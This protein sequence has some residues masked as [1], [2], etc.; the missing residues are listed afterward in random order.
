MPMASAAASRRREIVGGQEEHAAAG[1]GPRRLSAERT[2]WRIAS[3]SPVHARGAHRRDRASAGGPS[4][5]EQ[6]ADRGEVARA[7]R[8]RH[9][10]GDLAQAVQRA[11]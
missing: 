8:V 10:L 5:V 1:T 6:R 2:A 7:Q 9:P 3:A 11:R 4:S